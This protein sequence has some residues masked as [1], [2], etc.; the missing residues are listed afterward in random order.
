MSSK[1]HIGVF[2]QS[3]LTS[4]GGFNQELSTLESLQNS[5]FSKYTFTIFSTHKKT[6]SQLNQLGF[7]ATYIRFSFFNRL[8]DWIKNS[9][10]HFFPSML[11]T[12]H[13]S[14]DHKLSSYNCDLIYFL[15][16][17]PLALHLS[18]HSY[19]FTLWDLGHLDCQDFPEFK[20]TRQFKLRE[21]RYQHILPQAYATLVS[22]ESF[23]ETVKWRYRLNSKKIHTVPFITKQTFQEPNENLTDIFT[24]FSIPGP[25]IF[26]PAQFW[27][28]KN[29][30]YILDALSILNKKDTPIHAVFSGTDKG[31]LAYL[32]SYVTK[33]GLD[34]FIHFVGFVDEDDLIS[35]YKHSLALVMSTCL[36]PTNLPPLEAFNLGVPVIYPD[37]IGIKEF[38]EDAAFLVDLQTPN[39][40]VEILELIMN[41]S[42]LVTVKIKKGKDFI[43]NKTSSNLAIKNIFD[44]YFYLKKRW[45]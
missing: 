22:S 35:F 28:H 44:N 18:Q 26:Y 36:G 30:V 25:Y 33:L 27:S 39:H 23:K 32:K 2:F 5:S 31:N 3:D 37:Q 19:I 12:H 9:L 29:H 15:S 7:S 1:E 45:K 24:T 40:L 8:T 42:P 43:N 38:V 17:S 6:I 16:P 14:L 34:K 13:L 11:L 20:L 10:F 21:T 4:G 41:K